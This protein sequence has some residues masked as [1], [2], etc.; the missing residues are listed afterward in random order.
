MVLYLLLAFVV[1]ATLAYDRFRFKKYELP[2]WMF[3]TPPGG[4][5]RCWVVFRDG[6]RKH[7]KLNRVLPALIEK[8]YLSWE[9]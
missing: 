1:I 4:G 5:R 8:R 2:Y 9:V 7:V 6:P 3:S